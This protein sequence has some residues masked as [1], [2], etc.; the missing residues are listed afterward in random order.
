M[1]LPDLLN[2]VFVAETGPERLSVKMGTLTQLEFDALRTRHQD[3]VEATARELLDR[4]GEGSSSGTTTACV[5]SWRSYVSDTSGNDQNGTRR[6]GAGAGGGSDVRR[7]RQCRV[8][9]VAGRL[10]SRPVRRSSALKA[11]DRSDQRR[12]GMICTSAPLHLTTKQSVGYAL[13]YGVKWSQSAR[14]VARNAG[15]HRAPDAH[16]HGTATCLRD[17]RAD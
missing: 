2:A 9:A 16:H 14:S 10:D 11:K 13:H 15:P 7:Q 4:F 12:R 6:L 17:C 3:F 1:A 8:P 5:R